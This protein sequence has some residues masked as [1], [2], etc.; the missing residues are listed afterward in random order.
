MMEWLTMGGHGPFI[1]GS[2]AV[3]AVVLVIEVIA[4]R[5]RRRAAAAIAGE[6]ARA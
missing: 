5:A 6:G 1:W 3:T 2:Y 4:L